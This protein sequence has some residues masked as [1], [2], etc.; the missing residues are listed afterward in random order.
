MFGTIATDADDI[1]EARQ[2][3]TLGLL[4]STMRY[5]ALKD[6]SIFDDI[7]ISNAIIDS[8]L[9]DKRIPLKSTY[10]ESASDIDNKGGRPEST[11]VT[12]DG[13][14]NDGD[15]PVIREGTQ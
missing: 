10:T 14:E 11:E 15:S 8:G 3:M 13:N 2:G 1:E 7:S 9:M 4:P 12:S 5:L 6:M